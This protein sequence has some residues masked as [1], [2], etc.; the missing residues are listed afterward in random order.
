MRTSLLYARRHPG[1]RSST[2][3][4]VPGEDEFPLRLAPTRPDGFFMIVAWP[5]LAAATRD[6]GGDLP[7]ELRPRSS[8]S[9]T[10]ATPLR[11]P[12]RVMAERA[13]NNPKISSFEYA[14]VEE[15]LPAR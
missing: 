12:S 3:T 5:S 2:V 14:T 11:A 9:R 8:S 13:L 15:V 1:Y 10:A 7:D 6:G 4:N